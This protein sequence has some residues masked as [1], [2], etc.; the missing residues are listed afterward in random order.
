MIF[1]K[2]Q[3]Y[4]PWPFNSF[5]GMDLDVFKQLLYKKFQKV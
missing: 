3:E 4:V 2:Y 5:Q 1:N